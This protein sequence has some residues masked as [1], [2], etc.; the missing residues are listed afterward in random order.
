MGF[1]GLPACCTQGNGR[2]SGV[3]GR[4]EGARVWSPG[5]LRASELVL[6]SENQEA[7]GTTSLLSPR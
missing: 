3:S 6:G 1:A 4:G 5:C 2:P 7:R